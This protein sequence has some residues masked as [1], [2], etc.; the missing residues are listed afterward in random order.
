MMPGFSANS[1]FFVLFLPPVGMYVC[2]GAF[3]KFFFFLWVSD[4]YFSLPYSFGG[5]V[6]Y[7][8]FSFFVSSVLTFDGP[9]GGAIYEV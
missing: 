7:S 4:Y 6:L 8:F 1:V 5:E 9:G 3:Q 2:M